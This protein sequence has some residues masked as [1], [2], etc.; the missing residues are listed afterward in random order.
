MSGIGASTGENRG[1]LKPFPVDPQVMA[2]IRPMEAR[3]VPRVAQLH[4]A[5]MGR[6][7]WA[8]LGRPF[9][10]RVYSG[11]VQ[12][13]H[14]LGFVYEEEGRVRGFIGGSTDSG[15]LFRQVLARQAPA[16][17]VPSLLGILRNPGL[18]GPVF[19]T[20]RYFLKSR[21]PSE[22]DAVTAESMFCSFEPDL[23]G[24]RV[25]GHINKVLFDELAA[26]G[27]RKMK[28]T[29]E[30]DNEGAVRQLESWGFKRQGSFFFYG[31]EMFIY[32]L[33]L[34]TCERVEA[35]SRHPAPR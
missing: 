14:F 25:S 24:R 26:R 32:L 12:S 20:P 5:A 28:I 22:A 27:H 6:S 2:A 33:D 4:H 35:V 30:A 29:T 9:L 15:K 10:E 21:V 1:R 7:L 19:S 16:L 18:L 11:L 3:D 13:P 23:R 34:E 31:K 17:V 8:R